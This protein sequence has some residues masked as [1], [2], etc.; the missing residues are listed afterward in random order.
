M[1]D[2]DPRLLPPG[3]TETRLSNEFAEVRV[4]KIYTRNG[5]RLRI[6]SPRLGSSVELDAIELE[7]LSWQTHEFFSRLLAEPYGPSVAS[8]ADAATDGQA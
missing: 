3:E 7:S 8:Q 1:N 4:Q 6:W 5:E 2:D